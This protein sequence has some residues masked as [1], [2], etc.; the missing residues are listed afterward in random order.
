MTALF[1][2]ADEGADHLPLIIDRGVERQ[3]GLIGRA[4]IE[5]QLHSGISLKGIQVILPVSCLRHVAGY[6]V[7]LSLHIDKFNEIK[8][9][10]SY[11]VL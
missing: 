3:E 8:N 4:G 1:V 2:N 11:R 9:G 5:D 10:I 7:V 6:V